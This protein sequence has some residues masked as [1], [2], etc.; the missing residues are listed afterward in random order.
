MKLTLLLYIAL[1][2]FKIFA[3][4]IVFGAPEF[5]INIFTIDR[6][7]ISLLAGCVLF[8]FNYS[9]YGQ[10]QSTASKS[11]KL[12]L[13]WIVIDRLGFSLYLVH[14]S[15][16]NANVVIQKQPLTME[17]ILIVSTTLIYGIKLFK[18]VFF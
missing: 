8:L 13:L 17:L 1:M 3:W 5:N 6:F 7:L 4:N 12:N 18:L 16:I 15:V 14:L 10:N 11:Y 2:F 9:S